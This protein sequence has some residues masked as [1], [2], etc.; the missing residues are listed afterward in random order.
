M[1]RRQSK[2]RDEFRRKPTNIN[3]RAS[4]TAVA[5]LISAFLVLLAA[6]QTLSPGE[7][8]LSSRPYQFQPAI[9]FESRLVQLEVVV[10]DS[11]GRAVSGLTKDNFA[12]FDAG[13][14]RDLTA[15]SVETFN[16]TVDTPSHSAS[17]ASDATAQRSAPAPKSP[18]QSAV[19][20]RWIGLLFDDINT[21]PGDLAHAKIAAARFIKEAVRTGDRVAIFTTSAG[22]SVGFTYDPA[23]ILA[24]MT[25]IQSHPRTSRG[26]LALC[27]RMTAY[28]AY[29]IVKGDPSATKA[30]VVEACSCGGSDCPYLEGVP[31]SGFMNLT[32]NNGGAGAVPID[33]L[34]TVLAQAQQTWDQAHITSHATLDAIKGSLDQL[35]SRPGKRMLLLA[36]SGFLS[37]MLEQEQDAIINEAVRAD[38][39]INSLD[40]KGLYAEAPGTPLDET[41]E[42][43]TMTPSQAI[44]QM[45]TVGDNLEELD[46][47]MARF[48]ESTGGLL[49]RNNNDLNLGFHQ[50]GLLPDCM[51][52]LGFDP[53]DD[54]KYHKIKV[55][56]KNVSHDFLQVRPGYF[57]PGKASAEQPSA[58]NKADDIDT[59]IRG[60]AEKSDLPATITEKFGTASSGNPQLTIQTHIDIQKLLFDQQQD[61]HV[62]KLTFVAALF[63][64]RGKFVT[65]K[66]ADMELALKPESFDRL[67]KTG[68]N[69]VMQLE[70]PAGP[71]RLRVVVQEAFHG[72]MSA[73]TKELEIR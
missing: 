3:A 6:A 45:R 13:N 23:A 12:V 24:A 72:R 34:N 51:Y 25:K 16:P 53:A 73:T 42:T 67:S 60:S 21:A 62:Q 41:V 1:S 8:R 48:A 31:D 59:E 11:H 63:D 30:K 10:R 14:K 70:A 28:E 71:Y 68:I 27:P 52:L 44:F 46:S 36:S 9:R 55:E 18:N 47:S 56:L 20:G 22:L 65:G 2:T 57:A 43:L 15:F 38:V 58:A 64:P 50:L 19:S 4:T 49:F 37:G 61:R 33:L 66:Q 17:A 7:V 35:A 54:G 5:V 40:A 69:G 26:G 29:Q 39:V 32:P